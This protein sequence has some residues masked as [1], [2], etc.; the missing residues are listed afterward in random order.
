MKFHLTF[1]P[2]YEFSLPR[3]FRSCEKI[4][5]INH[6]CDNFRGKIIINT[7]SYCRWSIR[8]IFRDWLTVL[9]LLFLFAYTVQYYCVARD[10]T[11]RFFQSHS[12]SVHYSLNLRP[13]VICGDEEWCLFNLLLGFYL[14]SG[15]ELQNFSTAWGVHMHEGLWGV[16]TLTTTKN[17][18]NLTLVYLY[19]H[20][21]TQPTAFLP[22][23]THPQNKTKQWKKY[24]RKTYTLFCVGCLFWDAINI[25][26]P[27]LLSLLLLRIPAPVIERHLFHRQRHHHYALVSA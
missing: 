21:T 20:N 19:K 24:H 15:C 13:S 26:L 3:N 11:S 5:T 12:T 17:E 27:Q 25:S 18:S 14:Y 2:L 22:T 10:V 16:L 9:L 1:L 4:R 8:N 6:S 23:H 7:V